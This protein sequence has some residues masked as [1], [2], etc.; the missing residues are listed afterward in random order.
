MYHVCEMCCKLNYCTSADVVFERN[1]CDRRASVF[2]VLY[3]A[4]GFLGCDGVHLKVMLVSCH[5]Y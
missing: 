3:A 4:G 1:H 2:S 5:L